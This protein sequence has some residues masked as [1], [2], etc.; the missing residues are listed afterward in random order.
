MWYRSDCT[1]ARGSVFGNYVAV[2][3]GERS[4]KEPACYVNIGAVYTSI[5]LVN[6]VAY[7]RYPG[8]VEVIVPIEKAYLSYSMQFNLDIALI[9]AT[10]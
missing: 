6:V 2:I 7:K 5:E 9:C 4:S 10:R 3:E 1:N 8:R